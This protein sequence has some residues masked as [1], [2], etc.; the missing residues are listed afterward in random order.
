MTE[1]HGRTQIRQG[2]CS[3]LPARTYR[4]SLHRNRRRK[5]CR[6]RC[7]SAPRFALPDGTHASLGRST[8]C[9]AAN[10]PASG[11]HGGQSESGCSGAGNRC[12]NQ[13]APTSGSRTAHRARSRS[14]ARQPFPR[15]AALGLARGC[16]SLNTPERPGQR[17]KSKPKPMCS[18]RRASCFPPLCPR[19]SCPP[20]LLPAGHTTAKSRP[21]DSSLT[22]HR[23]GTSSTVRTFRSGRILTVFRKLGL[24]CLK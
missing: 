7:R 14:C 9:K 10:N 5:Q 17:V 21:I 24:S 8:G 4:R 19:S 11:P 3:S 20:G 22:L 18:R 23:I 16:C 15:A 1:T 2:L 6:S 13:L 12:S